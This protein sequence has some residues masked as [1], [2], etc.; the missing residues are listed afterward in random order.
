MLC[1]K[2][3]TCFA[4][5]FVIFVILI[6]VNKLDKIPGPTQLQNTKMSAAELHGSTVSD[7][8]LHVGDVSKVE[9]NISN[10][11]LNASSNTRPEKVEETSNSD[12]D[13]SKEE[14]DDFDV[15]NLPTKHTKSHATENTLQFIYHNSMSASPSQSAGNIPALPTIGNNKNTVNKRRPSGV[16]PPPRE[17]KP[18]DFLYQRN[19]SSKMEMAEEEEEEDHGS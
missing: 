10:E 4:D 9:N 17:L 14:E 18:G 7:T 16:P 8:T 1:L 11:Q 13:V 5:Q 12:E 3:I 15:S 2:V 6:S 19:L